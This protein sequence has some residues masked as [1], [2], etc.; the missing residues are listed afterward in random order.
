[1]THRQPWVVRC[2]RRAA[3][4]VGLAATFSTIVP[5]VRAAGVDPVRA[6]SGR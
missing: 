1:M 4:G 6:I 3:I 5:A 2:Y